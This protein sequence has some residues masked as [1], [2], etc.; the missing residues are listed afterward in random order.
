MLEWKWM[1]SAARRRWRRCVKRSPRWRMR[2]RLGRTVLIS[3]GN[4]YIRT[5]PNTTGKIIGVALNGDKLPYGGEISDGG[6]PMVEHNGQKRLGQ[7][8]V[9]QADRLTTQQSTHSGFA[10]RSILLMDR[11]KEEQ[12]TEQDQALLTGYRQQGKG[13]TE[14]A[15]LLG[16]SVNT[17]KSLLSAK[18]DRRGTETLCENASCKEG[19]VQTMRG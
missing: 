3:G 2:S 14:I 13:C 11:W 19:N 12:M 6:W 4:C 16:V 9:R 7:R 10:L 17:V 1:A 5:A 8:Q 15:R 18:W